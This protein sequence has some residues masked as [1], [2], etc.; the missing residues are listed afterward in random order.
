[1]R[2]EGRDRACLWDILAAARE[3]QEHVAGLTFEQYIVDLKARRAIERTLEIIGEATGK[4]SQ[5]FRDAHPEIDGHRIKGL[6]NIISHE[7]D[8]VRHDLLWAVVKTDVPV[9]IARL[10]TIHLDPSDDS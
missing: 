9:L 5:A 10:E 6:R 8:K 4:V 7:Y 2:P 3:A 1:M